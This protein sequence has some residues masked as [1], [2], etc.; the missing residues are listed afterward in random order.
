MF[1][2]F[3]YYIMFEF[4]VTIHNLDNDAFQ[5]NKEAEIVRIIQDG[6]KKYILGDDDI[7]LM[8][9]EGNGVWRMQAGIKKANAY[10]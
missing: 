8:D 3:N 2:P 7:K 5:N 4:K 9:S 1:Y 10:R 6:L